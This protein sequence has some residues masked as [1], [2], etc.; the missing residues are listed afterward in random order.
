MSESWVQI[1]TV[2][3][4]TLVIVLSFFGIMTSINNSI[5]EDIRA[6][7][8]DSKEEIRAIHLEIK[9][10]HNRLCAIEERRLKDGK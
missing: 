8:N 6:L 4:S 2:I 7:H 10:F 9:D 3:G 5:R 1:L